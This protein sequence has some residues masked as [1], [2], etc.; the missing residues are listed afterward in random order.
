MP[1]YKIEFTETRVY[2]VDVIAKNQEQA[3][4][5]ALKKY[6]ELESKGILHY[7]ES[8]DPETTITNAF[9]VTDTDDPFNP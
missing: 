4:K 6:E 5:K 8:E 3:E 2:I 7:N 1:K 9:D